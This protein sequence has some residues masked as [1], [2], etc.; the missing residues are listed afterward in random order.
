MIKLLKSCKFF[1]TIEIHISV[2]P[3]LIFF[4][5]KTF[6]LKLLHQLQMDFDLLN[7]LYSVCFWRRNFRSNIAQET[8][9]HKPNQF[10][11]GMS[12]EFNTQ[13]NAA[14]SM[15]KPHFHYSNVSRKNS[16]IIFHAWSQQKQS[17]NPFPL[18]KPRPFNPLGSMQLSK[19]VRGHSM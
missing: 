12:Y 7:V 2:S 9:A 13:N 19:R 1:Y 8:R 16:L 5:K 10:F 4:S 18:S 3:D 6:V 11:R 15:L 17:K 14:P